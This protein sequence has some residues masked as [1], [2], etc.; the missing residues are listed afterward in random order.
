M[1]NLH[2]KY[3]VLRN[4]V[5]L[6][7]GSK[8]IAFNMGSRATPLLKQKFYPF[9]P[10]KDSDREASHRRVIYI[11]S[12]TQRS[13]T[14]F[15]CNTLR[16]H[17][18]I[19][20][21]ESVTLPKEHFLY[22]HS[23]LLS[24][25]LTKT[26]GYWPKWVQNKEILSKTHGRLL[27]NMGDGILNVFYEMLEDPSKQLMLRTPDAGNLEY[28]PSLFPGGKIV[29]IIRDGRDTVNSFVESFS[30]DWAFGRMSR[31]WASRT[32]YLFRLRDRMIE[33]G[34][35]DQIQI[36]KYED[37]NKK[38]EET[39]KDILKFLSLDES[40]YDWKRLNEVPV[41]GSSTQYSKKES[42]TFWEPTKKEHAEKF[43]NKWSSWKLSKRKM[44][45]KI[46][47]DQLILAGYEADL[48]W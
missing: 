28:F 33:C 39:M 13:G 5:N 21:P 30:G 35:G 16:L 24:E 23:D 36:F 10:L 41:V 37:L 31:R 40:K 25:Y 46:A 14:N 17:S 6:L 22:S 19:A 42:E 48:N 11:C 18:E 1:I 45:K 8:G 32:E 7:K 38:P 29:V 15:I 27:A 34:L 26:I 44:F 43:S 20:Y 12:P 4:L 3:S 2:N 9:D 47:G